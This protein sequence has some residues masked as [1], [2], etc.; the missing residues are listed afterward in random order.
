MRTFVAVAVVLFVA[1]WWWAVPW[2]KAATVLAGW[3][4]CE[5]VLAA[6]RAKGRTR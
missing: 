1:A 6:W 5:I 2:W 3:T 4:S